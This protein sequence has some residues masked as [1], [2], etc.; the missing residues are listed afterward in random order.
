[1]LPQVG[2]AASLTRTIS[3][4]DI[5]QFAK[6]T[7]DEN[8][9]HVDETFAEKTRFGGRIAHGM[10]GASLIS[11][12]LGTELPGPGTIYLNQTLTFKGPVR[13]GDTI[14]AR[15]TVI[16]VREDKRILTLET[17]CENQNG[18]KIL[19][20]EAVVLHEEVGR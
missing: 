4:V 1:M 5:D 2:D 14:T 11:A 16:K 8:P 7:G 12:V 6:L 10:W 3:L 17:V 13:P 20:G 15:V 9:V 19:E 18:E